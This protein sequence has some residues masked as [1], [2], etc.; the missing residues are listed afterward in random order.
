MSRRS[1]PSA[2]P[3]RA[4]SQ[5]ES[6][7][8][9]HSVRVRRLRAPTVAGSSPL[10]P[11]P[12]ERPLVDG[13]ATSYD[14]LDAERDGGVGGS[15]GARPSAAAARAP[16]TLATR[17]RRN[18]LT[19][20]IF[21]DEQQ[22]LTTAATTSPRTR[23]SSRAS[24]S[25]A[26]TGAPVQVVLVGPDAD[27]HDEQPQQQSSTDN[28]KGRKRSTS[29]ISRLSNSRRDEFSASQSPLDAEDAL[30][31]D[32]EVQ[33]LDVLDQSVST[34]SHLANIQ[35]AFWPSSLS[36]RPVVQLE[37]APV[38]EEAG[39]RIHVEAPAGSSDE[40]LLVHVDED[41][42][43]L[44]THLVT[45]LR[46]QQRKQKRKEMFRQTMRGVVAFLKTP[47]GICALIYMLLV[48]VV[49]AALV[50]L[51]MIPM[52]SYAKKLWVEICSQILTGLFT[53][54]S[55]LPL[56]WRLRDW[57]N[58]GT[59][60][61]FAHATRKRRQQMHLPP[62]RD[63]N[64]LPEAPDAEFWVGPGGEKMVGP[65]PMATAIPVRSKGDKHGKNTTEHGEDTP[66]GS[67]D[68]ELKAVSGLEKVQTNLSE[69]EPVLSDKELERLRKAQMSYSKSQ[70]Y[71]RAHTTPTHHATPIKWAFI[72]ALLMVG[73][74]AFQAMLCG[75]MWG[76][77]RF[78][79]PAW[80][81]G[82]LIPLSFGCM[83]AA[84]IMIWQAGERTKRKA[85]VTRKVWLML[86]KD[87]EELEAKRKAII[88]QRH[89]EKEARKRHHH[90][91][92]TDQ[93]HT[94]ATRAD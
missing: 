32:Q 45:L 27:T 56:P 15:A 48:V 28:N 76:L 16:T 43:P 1:P 67:Q 64:D 63:P 7:G 33:L 24:R 83:I 89:A 94:P 84:S 81:T 36:R 69:E 34:T 18:T 42:D 21:G 71:Y 8:A 59:I 86:K 75:V 57:Y 30:H 55:L 85:E 14:G 17:P 77:N 88:E 41:D 73:N 6:L 62:L 80:T 44:D 47:L 60:T 13:F 58:I 29:T 2:S 93:A 20:R 31:H 11:I 90:H 46:K 51:L 40:D 70:T 12:S 3:V 79:R 66:G 78:N 52:G 50:L 91:H 74:S 9:P 49:G 4:R 54:T 53:I 87:E 23:A 5:T 72:I 26:T 35:S 22:T 38:D 10:A 65:R 25:S 82:C 37:S 19:S 92:N 68:I 61:Y 39:E